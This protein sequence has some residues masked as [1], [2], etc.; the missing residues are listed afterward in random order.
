MIF[1]AGTAAFLVILPQLLYWKAQ[2][3]HYIFNSYMDQGK[4]FF[5]EPQI[6][7]GLFSY[8]KGW[9]IYT[10]IMILAI[11]GFFL[12]AKNMRQIYFLPILIFTVINIYMVY[13]WWCWWYGG[14]YGS[15]PM[16]D[17]YGIMAIPMAAILEKM[18]SGKIRLKS[19]AAVLLLGFIW[20]N[21]F[22]MNQ[23][24]TSLYTGTA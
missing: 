20:L 21:Q 11:F 12:V 2:T 17:I 18:L 24:R 1:L 22:Q 19:I 14:S 5:L 9:L 15:R 23:Y 16:I 4:F 3:G 13:S 10:L 8:R 6:I 7:N